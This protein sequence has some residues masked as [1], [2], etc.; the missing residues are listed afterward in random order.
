M[1]NVVTQCLG[2][3]EQLVTLLAFHLPIDPVRLLDRLWL[4]RHEMELA[5]HTTSCMA[6]WEKRLDGWAVDWELNQVTRF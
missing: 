6:E 3:L 4:I 1:A 2:C 5:T